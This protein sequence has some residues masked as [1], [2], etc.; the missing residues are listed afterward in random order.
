MVSPK[1]KEANQTRS[2]EALELS[3]QIKKLGLNNDICQ[4]EYLYSFFRTFYA[5]R[6]LIGTMDNSLLKFKNLQVL[7]LSNSKIKRV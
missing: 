4:E 1:L 3:Q 6:H 5:Q 7:N 2:D